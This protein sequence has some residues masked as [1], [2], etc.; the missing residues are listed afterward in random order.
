M[1]LERINREFEELL[2]E[3]DNCFHFPNQNH[4]HASAFIFGSDD[5]PYAG[6]MW[7]VKIDFPIDY[8]FRPPKV[9]LEDKIFHMNLRGGEIVVKILGSAWSPT[10]TIK[11]VRL[12]ICPKMKGHI[13]SLAVESLRCYKICLTFSLPHCNSTNALMVRTGW[14]C[15]L[16]TQLVT[17]QLRRFQLP[18][19]AQPH[20]SHRTLS[21]RCMSRE[22][23]NTMIVSAHVWKK[24]KRCVLCQY[25]FQHNS[26]PLQSSSEV[27][28][29]S[30]KS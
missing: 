15:M 18:I 1:A 28:A 3:N 10:V 16:P 5:T 24:T 2:G 21:R 9:R 20:C 7:K 30:S 12:Q 29:Q 6:G 25:P 11:N 22:E 26:P 27:H 17:G 23:P 19:S 8:P 14:W 13:H 4:F